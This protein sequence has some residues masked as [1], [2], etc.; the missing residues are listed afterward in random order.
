MTEIINMLIW[1][2]LAPSWFGF[3]I[4]LVIGFSIFKLL[5]SFYGLLSFNKKA[6]REF[7]LSSICIYILFLC[8]YEYEKNFFK[9][10]ETLDT[11]QNEVYVC[12][13]RATTESKWIGPSKPLGDAMVSLITKYNRENY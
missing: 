10:N 8:I 5:V 4:A 2:T 1:K 6:L 7:A 3:V 11:E 9:C 12:Y 13:M